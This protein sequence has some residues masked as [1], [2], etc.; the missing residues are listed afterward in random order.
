MPAGSKMDPLLAKAEPISNGVKGP[1][2]D[3][4]LEVGPHQC[5]VQRDNHFPSPAGYTISDPSQG[6]IGLLGHL[7]TLLAHIQPAL[8]QHPQVLFLQAAFQPPLPKPVALHG[9]VVTQVLDLALILV[10][11]HT[12]GFGQLTQPVQ[13][14]L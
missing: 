11:F 6:P 1:K 7:G 3:T 10:D 14:P 5:Q 13:I 8:D 12:I 2:L 4:V 9:V